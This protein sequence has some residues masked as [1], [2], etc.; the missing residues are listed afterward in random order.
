MA[1]RNIKIGDGEKDQDLYLVVSE[2]R[3]HGGYFH[4][5]ARVTTSRY[6]QGNGQVP[7]GCDDTYGDG[8]LVS[9]LRVSCQGDERS[10]LR[11]H[12]PVYGFEVEYAEVHALR[13]R[14]A[15]RMLKTLEYVERKLRKQYD[16]RGSVKTYGEYV[17]RV[18]EALGC[19]GIAVQKTDKQ[20]QLSGYRWDWYSIG[21]GVNQVN[22]RIWRWVREAQERQEQAS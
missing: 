7:Y 12:D 16:T 22:N 21:D 3:S 8:L 19:K 20:Y 1:K 9:G 17:G 13:V 11:E 10:Q 4:L 15:R 5:R 6:E 2:E 14:E 18:A